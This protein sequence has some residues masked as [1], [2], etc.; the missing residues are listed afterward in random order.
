MGAGSG[1]RV[2]DLVVEYRRDGYAI[3]PLDGLNFEAEKGQLVVL[4]GPSGTG[5]TTL[6]SCLG[7]ILTPTAGRIML[8]GIDVTALGSRELQAYRRTHVGF[9]FQAFNLIASL[10]ALDNVAAPLMLA[11]T[12]RREARKR[13]YELLERVGLTDRARHRR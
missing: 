3:R 7:G 8:G 6:L 12:P 4:L 5:K 2:E 1:L 13:A 9:V 10:D 11:G